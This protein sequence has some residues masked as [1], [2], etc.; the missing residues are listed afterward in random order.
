MR[1]RPAHTARRA[2]ARQREHLTLP[3]GPRLVEGV[4][5]QR[6]G[7][8][9]ALDIGQHRVDETVL[10][11]KP[12]GA[13]GTLDRPAKLVDLHRPEQVLVLGQRGCEARMVGASPVEVGPEGDH[14]RR[15]AVSRRSIRASMKRAR[16]ASSGQSVNTSSSWSTISSEGR[17]GGE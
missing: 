7:A 15:R 1:D 12:R 13:G 17:A 16:H 2:V 6:E 11:S 8:G 10:E 3:A 4:G 9:L 14:D 5:E